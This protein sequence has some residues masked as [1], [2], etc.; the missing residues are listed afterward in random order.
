MQ[1]SEDLVVIIIEDQFESNLRTVMSRFAIEAGYQGFRIMVEYVSDSTTPESM[2]SHLQSL[3]ESGL[4]GCLL[5]G[6]LSAP[7]FRQQD[8]AGFE[9]FPIDLYFMDLDGIFGDLNS[10]GIL[11]WHGG[12]TRPEIFFGRLSPT[13]LYDFGNASELLQTYFHRNSLYRRGMLQAPQRVLTF[14]DDDW[15]SLAPTWHSQARLAYTEGTLIHNPDAT[16]AT[17]YLQELNQSYEFVLVGAHSN[18]TRHAFRAWGEWDYVES[19]EI[20]EQQNPILFAN[21]FACSAADYRFPNYLAG[22]Y[23][24]SAAGPLAVV[25]STKTGSMYDFYTFFQMLARGQGLG[26]A[27]QA[28][29]ETAVYPSPEMPDSPQW[30]YGMTCMGD[31]T[32][33]VALNHSDADHD[34]LPAFWE[35]MFGLDVA[36]PDAARD[37]DADDLTNAEEFDLFTHPRNP[38]TDQ[39]GMPDGWE[40]RWELN[41]FDND[42]RGDYDMDDLTN[43][44]EYCW[45]CNPW[46]TDTDADGLRDA[47]EIRMGTNPALADTDADGFIDSLDAFPT[48]HWAFIVVPL[49]CVPLI[50]IIIVFAQKSSERR[51]TQDIMN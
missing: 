44:E 33:P 51:A 7:V 6:N 17:A 45:N 37:E 21:L 43:Y 41:L 12:N 13:T 25:A 47:Y 39:D 31:P 34:G 14:I 49:L 30:S 26:P 40:F 18:P 24:F 23:V 19:Q 9:E 32:L 36:Q 8:G 4:V 27:L 3:Y 35:S 20:F 10:D 1:A 16:S 50:L 11:D 42:S 38:D 22:A 2:R 28:W 48:L 15:T 29:L 5:I 46:D